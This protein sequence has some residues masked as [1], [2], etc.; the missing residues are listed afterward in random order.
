MSY[1]NVRAMRS[2]RYPLMGCNCGPLGQGDRSWV[3]AIPAPTGSV[4][5]LA[6]LAFIGL[7]VIYGFTGGGRRVSPNRRRRRRPRRPRR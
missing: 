4:A 2:N 5:G 6:G 1:T 3:E 7:G